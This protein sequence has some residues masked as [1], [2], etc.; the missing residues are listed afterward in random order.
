MSE[1]EESV[2]ESS[3]RRPVCDYPDCGSLTLIVKM[4]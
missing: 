2:G 4:C 1:S 3:A